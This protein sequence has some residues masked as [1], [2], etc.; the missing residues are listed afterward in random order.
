MV[1]IEI[2]DSPFIENLIQR[3]N[4]YMM[5]LGVRD[6]SDSEIGKAVKDTALQQRQNAN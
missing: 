4:A 6:L 3:L 5:R 2:I 1:C